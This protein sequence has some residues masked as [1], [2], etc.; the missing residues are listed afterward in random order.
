MIRI[1]NLKE[2]KKTSGKRLDCNTTVLFR[3]VRITNK[4][5]KP[6]YID[7]YKRKAWKK[8]DKKKS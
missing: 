6:I 8:K 5:E 4:T 1:Q 7:W 2:P 3:G